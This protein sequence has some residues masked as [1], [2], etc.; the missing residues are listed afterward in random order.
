MNVAEAGAIAQ[1]SGE[2]WAEYYNVV[3]SRISSPTLFPYKGYNIISLLITIPWRGPMATERH[4]C[5]QT[6]SK[7]VLKFPYTRF[8]DL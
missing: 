3:I 4:G 7:R 1:H 2:H 8:Q 6:W 5:E